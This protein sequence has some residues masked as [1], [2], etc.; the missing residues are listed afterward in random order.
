MKGIKIMSEI[1]I[2]AEPRSQ[3]GGSIAK[4]MRVRG[5]VPGVLYGHGEPSIPFHVK[6]LDLR[7]LIY[8]PE[9]LHNPKATPSGKKEFT[10]TSLKR[11]GY[12]NISGIYKLSRKPRN[13]LLGL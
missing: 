5:R 9:T 12:I 13:F 11:R 2:K 6:E 3:L 1:I 8:T 4:Q 7:P 10:L